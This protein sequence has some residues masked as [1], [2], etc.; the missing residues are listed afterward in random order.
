VEAIDVMAV[1]LMVTGL[2]TFC[3]TVA[4]FFLT[5]S[6]LLRFEE[7]SAEIQIRAEHHNQLNTWTRP[8]LDGNKES[9]DLGV[10]MLKQLY[11]TTWANNEDR[12]NVATVLDAIG[13]S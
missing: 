1:T 11:N 8:V 10:K 12:V 4:S 2:A 5:R 6:R 7:R 13:L 9:R 3:W